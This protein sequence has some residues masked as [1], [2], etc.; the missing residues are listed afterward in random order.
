MEGGGIGSRAENDYRQEQEQEQENS[1]TSGSRSDGSKVS[2]IS[3]FFK[4]FM[5][6]LILYREI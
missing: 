3:V 4:N 2:Q 5:K 6:K 1:S